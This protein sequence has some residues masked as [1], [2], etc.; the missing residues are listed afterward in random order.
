[1]PRPRSIRA[2]AQVSSF[3][4]CCC[5]ILPTS[6]TAAQETYYCF[7]HADS[8]EEAVKQAQLVAVEDNPGYCKDEG[9]TSRDGARRSLAS[10]FRPLL[11]IEGH[12][13]DLIARQ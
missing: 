1:M 12:H 7:V 9:L 11:C 10:E 3:I 5:S 8:V 4:P 13:H 2:P 6:T